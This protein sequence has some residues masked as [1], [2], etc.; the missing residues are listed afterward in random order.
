MTTLSRA[1]AE[2]TDPIRGIVKDGMDILGFPQ[3]EQFFGTP[4]DWV[5]SFGLPTL[6]EAI[7]TPAEVIAPAVMSVRQGQPMKMPAP[8]IP[9]APLPADLNRRLMSPEGPLP[10]PATGSEQPFGFFPPLPPLP[11]YGHG[12]YYQGRYYQDKRP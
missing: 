12:P 10:T 1:K 3:I 5:H 8:M 4:A 6:H 9:M 7:P 11:G 2:P